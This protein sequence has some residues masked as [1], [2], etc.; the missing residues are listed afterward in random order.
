MGILCNNANGLASSVITS[1]GGSTCYDNVVTLLFEGVEDE[2]ELF[3]ENYKNFPNLLY[4][5]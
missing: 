5:L 1:K 4:T 2:K 3:Q